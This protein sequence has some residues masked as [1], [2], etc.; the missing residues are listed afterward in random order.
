MTE[1][2]FRFDKPMENEVEEKIKT[3]KSNAYSDPNK[4]D[5]IKTSVIRDV[6]VTYPP[7]TGTLMELMKRMFLNNTG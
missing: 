4:R 1:L 7:M 2:F 5:H 3:S 6:S